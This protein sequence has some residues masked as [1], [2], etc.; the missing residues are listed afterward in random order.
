MKSIKTL[1][2]TLIEMKILPMTNPFENIDLD[3][4]T[5]DQKLRLSNGYYL[6]G[7]LIKQIEKT[8]EP[9]IK[10]QY[11]DLL[12]KYYHSYQMFI[13]SLPKK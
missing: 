9:L 8:T 10:A 7:H 4:L 1:S 11:E 2:L 13:D 6:I 5:Y 12:I 3:Q